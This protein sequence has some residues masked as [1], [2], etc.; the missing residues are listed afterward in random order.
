MGGLLLRHL[1]SIS[2]NAHEVSE[3]Q[4]D[5]K[6]K[7]PMASSCAQGIGAGIYAILSLF[8]H[9]CDPHVTRT[10][11]G[12]ECQ[13]RAL[14]SCK[15]G[16][17]VLDNYGVIYAVNEI[18]ERRDKLMRQ[19]YFECSCEACEKKWPLYEAMPPASFEKVK[20]RCQ[21]CR[22]KGKASSKDCIGCVSELDNLKLIQF[23]AQQSLQALL[24]FKADVDLSDQAIVRKV[25]SGFENYCKYITSLE[26]FN[27]TRP[28][29]DYNNYEEAI[30]QCLNLISLRY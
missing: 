9:S 3:L 15:S 2:C 19:Y 26:K 8:N 23:N 25:Q 1:Q 10:F 6:A 17:E 5:R 7:K 12:L 21:E 18:S 29:Q 20:I 4:L 24:A 11:R 14:R 30:K 16:Q 28:F 27:V 13:V 22:D